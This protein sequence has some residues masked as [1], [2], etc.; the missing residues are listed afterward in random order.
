ML[1][2][3]KETRS[4]VDLKK[5]GLGRYVDHADTEIVCICFAI[6]DG[7]VLTWFVG[8]VFPQEVTEYLA[9]DGPIV[10]HNAIFEWAVWNYVGTVKYGFQPIPFTRFRC[11]QAQAYAMALP[12][13][14]E[15][16]ALALGIEH[17]KD[18]E[19]YR[20]MM[21]MCR[22]HGI[23]EDG[24]YIWLEEPAQLKRLAQYCAQDVIVER[25]IGKRTLPLSDSELALFHIDQMIN[26]RGIK[27]DQLSIVCAMEVADTETE[28][29]NQQLSLVTDG[30]VSATTQN[31]AFARWLQ[32]RGIECDGVAKDDVVEI[33]ERENVPEDV[34]LALRIRRDGAK[35]SVAKLSKMLTMVSKDGRIRGTMQYHGAQATGR[36]AGR[37]IQIH[38][39][40]RGKYEEKVTEEI[41][42]H[43]HKYK[44]LNHFSHLGQPLEIISNVLRSFIIAEH[45]HRFIAVDFNAIESRIL[46]WLA[47][48]YTKLELFKRGECPYIFLASNIYKVPYA[49][50]NKKDPRR[51]LGKVG[52]LACG[53]QGGVGAIQAMAKMFRM[54]LKDAECEVIKDGFRSTHPATV[55]F[56]YKLERSAIAAVRNPGKVY[57]VRGPI[58]GGPVIAYKKAGS[59]LF[60]KLPSGRKISYPY[61]KIEPVKTPWGSTK[62]GLTYMGEDSVSRKWERQIGYGGLFAENV[63]QAVGRDCLAE[64]IK[65]CELKSYP[66]VFHVHDE[67]VA[68]MPDGRGSL[69]EMEKIMSV[70]PSWAAGLPIVAEGFEAKRYRK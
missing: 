65:R 62:D 4:P 46:A 59:F 66:V 6:D 43:L 21:K 39:F 1:H 33:L 61:P 25:E 22:P 11:T 55:D 70:V 47:G 51:Q 2:V 8:E 26:W 49:E 7:P 63:A 12:P 31:V 36:W 10:A 41:F 27:V 30:A 19:G 68:E 58:V 13:S 28:K 64:A 38:N 29:L 15:K 53:F 34:Q 23:K 57:E 32:S 37:G 3:D 56:W 69:A 35:S 16:A 44:H 40:P 52:E 18:M 45:G 5:E 60:C 14:L 24:H 20:L 54:K 48:E 67:A 17:Q 50:I 9:G 42:Q